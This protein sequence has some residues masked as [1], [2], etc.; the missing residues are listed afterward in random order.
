MARGTGAAPAPIG[1]PRALD[2]DASVRIRPPLPEG[3]FHDPAFAGRHTPGW[4]II[5]TRPTPSQRTNTVGRCS[6]GHVDRSA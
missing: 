1:D 3:R 2:L 4:Q 6:D 5:R